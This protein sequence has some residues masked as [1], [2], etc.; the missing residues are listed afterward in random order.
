MLLVKTILFT[1]IMPGTVTLWAPYLVN[2]NINI[3]S[4]DIGWLKW[5]GIVSIAL[6]ICMYCVCAF[7]FMNH[8]KGTPAPIDAP[9]YLVKNRL[10]RYSRNPM[11]IGIFLI[12]AGEALYF[13]YVLQYI[14]LGCFL[15]AVV[16]FVRFYEEPHLQ[17]IFGASYREYCSNVRRWI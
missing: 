1:I 14:Y 15:A 5:C 11:Y 10:Y 16:T 12:L 4:V 6:G 9:K 2:K 13:G 8:G 7:D 17:K 3:G